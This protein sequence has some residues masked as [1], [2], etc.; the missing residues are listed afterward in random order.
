VAL[1]HH[2]PRNDLVCHYCS[3]QYAIPG[4]CPD[5]ESPELS[6]M[7]I[8]TQRIEQHVQQE[9]PRARLIRLDLDTTRKRTAYIDAWRRIERGD[10]DIIV[11]TQMIAKGLHLEQVTLVGV[12]LA[13]VSLFQPD[14]RSA[15]RAFSVLT[16]VAGRAGRGDK[17]GLVLIQTYVPLHYA[18]Q[19]AQT[20]D[21]R[22]FYDKEIHVRR[23]LR[24]PPHCRLISVLASGPDQEQT[25]EQIRELARHVRNAAMRAND[26]VAV[27]GPAPAPITK[28]NDRYR[29]RLFLRGKEPRLM[30]AVLFDALARHAETPGHTKVHM[31]IDVDPQDLM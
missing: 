16:Q 12:P 21:Y 23:V 31:A 9:F 19:Y 4:K 26:A 18:I 27:L 24:F 1:T 5:C 7:G 28:I 10:A 17:P 13:D 29:W 20:H 25:A 30:R 8:G 15:E 22:G 6:L 2:K 14:F 3:R 11:G